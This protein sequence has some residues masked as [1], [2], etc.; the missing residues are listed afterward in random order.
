MQRLI[1]HLGKWRGENP[2]SSRMCKCP[3]N[4]R[5]QTLQ[6]DSSVHLVGRLQGSS[7]LGLMDFEAARVTQPISILQLL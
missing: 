3:V 2:H 6:A 7:C 1:N 5:R 4:L